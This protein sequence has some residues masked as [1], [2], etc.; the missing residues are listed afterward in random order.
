[1][2]GMVSEFIGLLMGFKHVVVCFQ[3]MFVAFCRI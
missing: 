3:C 1:M 2:E